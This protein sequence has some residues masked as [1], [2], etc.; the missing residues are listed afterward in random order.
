MMKL[1]ENAERTQF[2]FVVIDWLSR[3][4]LDYLKWFTNIRVKRHYR[5]RPVESCR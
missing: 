3:D 1:L 2:R 5:Y 4:L